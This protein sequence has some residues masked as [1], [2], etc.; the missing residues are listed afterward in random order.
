M[1]P[2]KIQQLSRKLRSSKKIQSRKKTLLFK[3]TKQKPAGKKLKKTKAIEKPEPV[4]ID[5]AQVPEKDEVLPSVVETGILYI[6][7]FHCLNK[8]NMYYVVKLLMTVEL[9]VC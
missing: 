1:P 2:S 3:A 7:G 5:D 9:E 8:L 6:L 4:H